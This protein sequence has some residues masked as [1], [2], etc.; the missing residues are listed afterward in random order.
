MQFDRNTYR[1]TE[2]GKIG[3]ISGVVGIIGLILSG[4]GYFVDSHQFFHSYLTAFFFWLSIALGGLFFTMLHYIVNAKWSVVLRRLGE[5]FMVLVRLMVVFAI[6]LVFGIKELFHWSDAELVATDHLLQSKS[7]YLNLPFFIIRL[8]VYFVVWVLLATYL[9]RLSLNQD[10]SHSPSILR[11]ARI[12]SA[13]GLI[14]F[15]LT[16][17]F[18]AFDWLMSLDAHWYSTIFGVYI[19]AGAFLA[20]LS[21][22]TL[23]TLQLRNNGVLENVVTQEHDHDLGKLMFAF[24]IFW[25]YMAFSQYFLIW[26][27]NI[28][29]ETVWFL[30]RWENSWK[31]VTLVL[32]FGHFIIP[33]FVLF[34]QG[35][36]RNALVLKIMAI[37]LLLMHWVDL[38]WIV[39]PSL[40]S[41][42][43]HLSWIDLATMVGIGGVFIW[44][45]WARLA[46]QPLVP[47]N[48]PGLQKSI[49]F[50]NA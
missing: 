6:P 4:V 40:H 3:L 25:G 41:H 28:P 35:S 5:N 11:R 7:G 39:M 24:T 22:M 46:K 42:D 37:W 20:F 27:G 1:L 26:Y 31:T 17:T 36:K 34:P 45:F 10:Q 30:H 43:V 9:N 29:E 18:A 32:V 49:N 14:L 47:V 23:V 21:L 44:Y 12:M 38:Y 16:T 2:S 13:P 19:F 33:F 50:T 15:A 8:C 48:D